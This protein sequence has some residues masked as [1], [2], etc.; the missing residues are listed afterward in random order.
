MT[1]VPMEAP[2]GPALTTL[3]PYFPTSCKECAA[4]TQAFFTCFE[5]HAFM[6]D[7]SDR[8]TAATSLTNCQGELRG[9]MACMER[10]LATADRKPWWRVLGL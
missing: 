2:A 6:K 9:Y 5:Q 10:H 7:D 3:P 4:P 1:A 8:Q